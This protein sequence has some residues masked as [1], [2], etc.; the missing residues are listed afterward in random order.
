MTPARWE[1]R[2]WLSHQGTAWQFGWQFLQKGVQEGHW[3]P[4][5]SMRE[6]WCPQGDRQ[7]LC[8]LHSHPD[9]GSQGGRAL[10]EYPAALMPVGEAEKLLCLLTALQEE[11]SSLSSVRESEMD[12]HWRHCLKGQREQ[13]SHPAQQVCLWLQTSPVPQG[14]LLMPL[15]PV[16]NMKGKT[17]SGRA[18]RSLFTI[19]FPGGHSWS[20]NN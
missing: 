14:T 6:Q 18:L 15:G 1:N 20:Y 4:A 10:G 16:I 5:S 3:S 12:W 19:D 2:A 8:E 9:W 7:D 11:R 17:F 13:N